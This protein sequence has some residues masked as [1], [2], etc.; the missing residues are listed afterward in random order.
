MRPALALIALTAAACAEAA[1]VPP[2]PTLAP[3]GHA[4]S[5][6]ARIGERLFNET[7]FAQHFLANNKGLN[8]P[9]ARGDPSLDRAEDFRRRRLT[10]AFKGASMS[11]RACHIFDEHRGSAEVKLYDDF[12]RASPIPRRGDELRHAPRNAPPLFNASL[13]RPGEVLFHYDGE[14]ESLE[15]LVVATLSGRNYGYLADEGPKAIAHIAA[16]LRQDNGAGPLAR[17]F[18]GRPYRALLEGRD[19]KIPADQ[20][21]PA[22]L[23]VPDVDAAEDRA[24]ATAAAR[25]IA[26]FV[27]GLE[28][29][30]DAEG[31]FDG[32]SYDAFLAANKLPRGPSKGEPDLDYTRRLSAAIA[33]LKKPRWITAEGGGF[34]PLELEGLRIFLREPPL[35]QEQASPDELRLGHI[36]NCAVCH[37]AP[38]FTD[39]KFHNVGASQTEYDRVFGFTAFMSLPVPKLAERNKRPQMFLPPSAEHP[40]ALGLLRSPPTRRD[41]R[42]ADLGLWNIYANPSVPGPQKALTRL[43]LAEPDIFDDGEPHELLD[44]AIARFKT[45]HLRGLPRSAPYFHNGGKASLEDL[46]QHYNDFSSLA[47]TGGARNPAPELK[48]ISLVDADKKPLVAFLKALDERDP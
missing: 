37:P 28:L 21:L 20:R 48:R 27:A 41:R 43:L 32:S 13:A 45:A 24:L 5:P 44:F 2:P 14:F 22:E 42:R 9:L 40:K 25:L 15:A 34:G 38:S 33:R 36:G 19:P 29:S 17:A 1:A 46:I 8:A 47:R 16:V 39:F 11:C 35:G 30:R 7:R 23:R 4:R 10:G 18:G 12:A 26:A 31:Y 6:A 3:S